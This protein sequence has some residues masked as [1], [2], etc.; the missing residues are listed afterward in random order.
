MPCGYC[1]FEPK[2]WSKNAYFLMYFRPTRSILTHRFS[3][4]Y[5]DGF[6]W[7]KKC[8]IC[9]LFSKSHHNDGTK[10][11]EKPTFWIRFSNK[12]Q[13]YNTREPLKNQNR[14]QNPPTCQNHPTMTA[15]N[16]RFSKKIQ[17]QP[18]KEVKKVQNL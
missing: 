4:C 18:L 12:T 8:K 5:D 2:I 7:S 10:I 6:W 15:K 9:D 17:N 16:L 1:K 3:W 14:T 11:S 13:K